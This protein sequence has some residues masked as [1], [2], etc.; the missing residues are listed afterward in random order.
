MQYSFRTAD[1]G[2]YDLTRVFRMLR[3]L[4]LLR[5]SKQAMLFK[6][7]LQASLPALQFFVV[8]SFIVL[9][10][11][12]TFVF[13]FMKVRNKRP[14]CTVLSRRLL[15]SLGRPTTLSSKR[16]I[17]LTHRVRG[18][19]HLPPNEMKQGEYRV[20]PENPEGA[21]YRLAL[22]GHHYEISPFDSIVTTL[23]WV[24]L[25]A[26]RRGCMSSSFVMTPSSIDYHKR[27][28]RLYFLIPL[29]PHTHTRR[30]S[31]TRPRSK[32]NY[33]LSRPISRVLSILLAYAGVILLAL[34]LSIIGRHFQKV[35]GASLV[36]LNRWLVRGSHVYSQQT[37]P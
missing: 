4:K 18:T 16:L 21:L 23:Y 3:T 35:G 7:T 14:R 13:Y 11:I 15:K 2:L 9:L 1:P 22:T 34:P 17:E 10:F 6:R 5:Y 32:S 26:L 31:S 27:P 30:R 25:L 8:M 24:R 36:L 29:V 28:A 19:W 33:P 37:P 20:T 12:S